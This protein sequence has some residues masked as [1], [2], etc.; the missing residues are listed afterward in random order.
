MNPEQMAAAARQG[1]Q[2]NMNVDL[3]KIDNE[4]CECGS[5]LRQ[6]NTI[7]KKISALVSPTG[8]EEIATIP[9]LSCALCHKGHPDTPIKFDNTP[10]SLIDT[11]V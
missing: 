2:M 4:K 1:Q 7:L 10:K 5:E 8:K 3:S 6:Q 11:D 9:V